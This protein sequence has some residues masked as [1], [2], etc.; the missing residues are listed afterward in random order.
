MAV[1]TPAG[2]QFVELVEDQLH[3]R[4]HLLVGIAGDF[5]GG[6]LDIP[7]GDVEDQLAPLG[8]AQPAAFQSIMHEHYLIF[9]DG[10]LKAQK[11]AVVGIAGVID[12]ILVRQ[13][14]SED[15]THLHEMMP[16]LVVAGD[17]AHLDPQDQA[18]M[19]HGKGP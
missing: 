18:D 17:A 8:L 6:Q 3:G 1:E 10:S 11:E 4:L 13:D 15:R 14:R 2:A 19:I 5:P 16:I 12:A 9:A 7:A